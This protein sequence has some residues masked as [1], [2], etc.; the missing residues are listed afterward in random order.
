MTTQKTTPK[1]ITEGGQ[2]CGISYFVELSKTGNKYKARSIV[3]FPDFTEI[4]DF[5]ESGICD[6]LELLGGRYTLCRGNHY[7]Y[8]NPYSVC[9]SYTQSHID[10]R[11]V[12]IKSRDAVLAVPMDDAYIV[13]RTYSQV[14]ADIN[15]LNQA[16]EKAQKMASMKPETDPTPEQLEQMAAELDRL[17][18]TFSKPGLTALT[19]ITSATITQ[20]MARGRVSA[21]AAH[22]ICKIK[23]IKA[24]GFTREKLRPD[25][26]FWYI[27]IK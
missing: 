21:Q 19:K 14:L 23:Q 9:L 7:F 24:Q 13:D 15:N 4:I 5:N 1:K 20:W 17:I 6:L 16:I 10:A 25:V 18:K 11:L 2:H 3:A 12:E 8:K 22:E 26:G 27:D